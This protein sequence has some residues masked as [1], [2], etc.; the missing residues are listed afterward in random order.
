[1]STERKRF[2]PEE[3]DGTLRVSRVQPCSEK[4]GPGARSIL[5]VV[6]CDLRCEGCI[7]PESHTGNGN[8]ADVPV[9]ELAELIASFEDTEGLTVSGG[10][11]PQQAGDVAALCQLLRELRGPNYTFMIY[12]G[13]PLSYLRKHAE[14]RGYQPLLDIADLW[15]DGPYLPHKHVEAAWR[16]SS[17]QRVHVLSDAY[18]LEELELERSRGVEFEAGEDGTILLNGVPPQPDFRPA[19]EDGLLLNATP[20]AATTPRASSTRTKGAAQ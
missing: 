18:T 17:N 16:G 14:A 4:L 6:G 10:N 9:S 1:M 5:Y 8:F 15:V 12:S 11:P 19:L 13:E 2:H 20:L 7:V 3:A